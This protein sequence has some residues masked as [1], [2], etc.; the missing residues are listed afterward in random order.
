M[1]SKLVV[2]SSKEGRV[3]KI[4]WWFQARFFKVPSVQWSS[5]HHLRCRGFKV[6]VPVP[7][8]PS[9]QCTLHHLWCRGF[10]VRVPTNFGLPF[11]HCHFF[12]LFLW[13]DS[14]PR[15]FKNWSLFVNIWSISS[16]FSC[17]LFRSFIIETILFVFSH[18][19]ISLTLTKIDHCDVT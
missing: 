5:L 9:V 11:W 12:C 3:N 13:R 14:N 16:I 17:N 6:R 15:R 19:L 7:Q 8:V 10:K 4:F 18:C 1:S 2:S